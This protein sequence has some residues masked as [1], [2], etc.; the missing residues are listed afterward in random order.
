MLTVKNLGS[1]YKTTDG[2]IKILN[3]INFYLNK[4]EIVGIIGEIGSGKT[5]L[6]RAIRGDLYIDSGDIL[7]NGESIFS[8][9]VYKRY[10][11]KV[12]YARQDSLNILKP[13]YS[14]DFQ[15]KKL[16]GHGKY[17]LNYVKRIFD[18]LDLP[19]ETLNNIP[20]RLSDG[21][22]H[23]VVI[24]MSLMIR[25]EILLLDEPFTGLDI[26]AITGLLK[27]L[28]EI[29]DY[30]SIIIVS[31]DVVPLFRICDRIY[32][33]RNGMILEDG[34]WS[35]ILYKPH[36]PYVYDIIN[37]IPSFENRNREFT[38]TNNMVNNGCVYIKRCRFMNESCKSEILYRY[39]NDHGYRCIRYPDWYNDRDKER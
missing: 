36:H 31:S 16:F 21:T 33:M 34:K 12:I 27:L 26:D 9:E 30:T 5:T 39:D 38:F 13:G 15:I 6:L 23:R 7:Y 8:R 3:D 24:A 20:S 32:A 11:E 29:K 17:D 19:M 10:R 1:G 4:N 14:V 22:R 18:Y 35:E 28:K 2:Y 37:A 25:P